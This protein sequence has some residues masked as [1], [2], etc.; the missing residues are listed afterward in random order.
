MQ[1]LYKNEIL[2]DGEE[3]AKKLNI[4]YSTFK[5]KQ[6]AKEIPNSI[7]LRTHTFWRLSDIEE[8]LKKFTKK[9]SEI[10]SILEKKQ[11]LEDDLKK[12]MEDKIV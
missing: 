7:K 11:K 2:I 3:A 9:Q 12:I 6:R 5:V 4:S 1:I 10:N 8:Y